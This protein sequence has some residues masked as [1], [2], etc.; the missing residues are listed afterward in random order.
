MLDNHYKQSSGIKI[1]RACVYDFN[2]RNTQLRA[3]TPF[4]C[5]HLT[6]IFIIEI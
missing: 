6:P 5:S 1:N 3:L 2:W 4:I